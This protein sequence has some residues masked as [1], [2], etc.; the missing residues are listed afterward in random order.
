VNETA[1]ARATQEAEAR[2][3]SLNEQIAQLRTEIEKRSA[4]LSQ[5]SA[6][7]RERKAEIQKVLEFFQAP[8]PAAPP[9]GT[10]AP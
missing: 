6:Q 5:L 1:T 9:T 3:K 8:G 10:A 2:I 7:A 4:G